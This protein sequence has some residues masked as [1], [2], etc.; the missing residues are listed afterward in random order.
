[1]GVISDMYGMV[2]VVITELS[3]AH[4]LNFQTQLHLPSAV[5]TLGTFGLHA[6]CNTLVFV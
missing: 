5:L 4:R 1:M 3:E 6:D 2:S